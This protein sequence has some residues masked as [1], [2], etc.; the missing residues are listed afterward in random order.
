MQRWMRYSPCLQAANKQGWHTHKQLQ[1]EIESVWYERD[2]DKL[3][4]EEKAIFNQRD[5]KEYGVT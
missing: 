1:Y 3:F 4:R 2:L 5:R